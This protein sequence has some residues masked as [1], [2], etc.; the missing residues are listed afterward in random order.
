MEK[1][2]NKNFILQFDEKVQE[3]F[4]ELNRSYCMA[5]TLMGHML[6]KYSHSEMLEFAKKPSKVD[7][8]ELINETNSCLSNEN[9]LYYSK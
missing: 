2:E 7:L 4:K 8:Q 5:Y 1:I 3:N 9:D 6:E